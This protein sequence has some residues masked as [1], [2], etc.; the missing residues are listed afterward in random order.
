MF[1]AVGEAAVRELGEFDTFST[2]A[3]VTIAWAYAKVSCTCSPAHMHTR[4]F[5][6]TH[7]HAHTNARMYVHV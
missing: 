3:L 7:V 2:H 4:I 6:C 5:A 1:E